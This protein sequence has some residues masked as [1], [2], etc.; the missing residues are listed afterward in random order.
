MLPDGSGRTEQNL[1][2]KPG[3][4]NQKKGN[5]KKLGNKKRN[6]KNSRFKPP[7]LKHFYNAAGNNLVGRL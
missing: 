3:G 5:L 4:E 7:G 2:K 1:G 6:I